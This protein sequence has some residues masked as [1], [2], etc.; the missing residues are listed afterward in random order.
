MNTKLK[1]EEVITKGGKTR[2]HTIDGKK[3][4]I[5]ETFV[6]NRTP[7]GGGITFFDVYSYGGNA[8]Q[9]GAPNVDQF[10]LL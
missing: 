3:D 6:R 1:V 5:S 4:A 9:F 10:T 2:S 8:A 7:Q